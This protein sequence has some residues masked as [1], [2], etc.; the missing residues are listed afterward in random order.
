MPEIPEHCLGVFSNLSLCK[1]STYLG[2]LFSNANVVGKLLLYGF[3]AYGEVEC[4]SIDKPILL[5]G[6]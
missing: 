3:T 2:S 4:G 5:Y 6:Q 1:Y